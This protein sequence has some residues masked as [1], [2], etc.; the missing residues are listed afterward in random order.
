MKF[1]IKKIVVALPFYAVGIYVIDDLPTL[2]AILCLA[3]AI[4]I[5]GTQEK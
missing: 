3:T 1:W 4:D 2:I 5:M